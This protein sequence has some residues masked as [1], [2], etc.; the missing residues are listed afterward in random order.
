M[1]DSGTVTGSGWES[2]LVTSAIFAKLRDRAQIWAVVFRGVWRKAAPDFLIGLPYIDLSVESEFERRYLDLLRSLTDQ[3]EEEPPLGKLPN[4]RM[5][6]VR[7][8]R[9]PV[10]VNQ[11]LRDEPTVPRSEDTTVSADY[12][13]NRAPLRRQDLGPLPT[14]VL[15]HEPDAAGIS[16]DL[17]RQITE[18]ER[19]RCELQGYNFDA[20]PSAPS[21][22]AQQTQITAWLASLNQKLIYLKNIRANRAA[23]MVVVNP[24]T[25]REAQE[26]SEAR[27]KK[28]S[29]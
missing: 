20:S 22:L 28:P 14:R 7:P 10:S 1:Q 19:R 27:Q 15:K 17:D 2:M 5:Q 9:G 3:Q 18:L 26:I 6:P 24:P 11:P 29:R 4:I 16:I 13:P 25:A 12:P 23:S 21:L 8:R